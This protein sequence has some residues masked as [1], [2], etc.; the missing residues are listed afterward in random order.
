MIDREFRVGD[1]VTCALYGIGKIKE[2][3][4]ELIYVNFSDTFNRNYLKDGR[5]CIEFKRTLFILPPQKPT[6]QQIKEKF[7]QLLDEVEEVEFK[8]KEK[9]Y[10]VELEYLHDKEKYDFSFYS[11]IYVENLYTKYISRLDAIRIVEQMNKF[12]KGK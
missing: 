7:K 2:I 4:D 6:K 10:H 12:I 8:H 3:D 1:R 5:Y 9:N 11:Y